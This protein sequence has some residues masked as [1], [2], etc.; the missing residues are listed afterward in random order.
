MKIVYNILIYWFARLKLLVTSQITLSF[1]FLVHWNWSHSLMKF[2]IPDWIDSSTIKFRNSESSS[3]LDSFL[4][5]FRFSRYKIQRKF[6]IVRENEH[7]YVRSSPW[8]HFFNS[9][10]NFHP[11][12]FH[13]LRGFFY[14]RKFLIDGKNFSSRH[15]KIF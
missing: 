2:V 15:K 11:I 13:N 1:L 7:I 4:S 10:E 12:D 14:P 3:F 6:S 9:A 5:Q 8:E